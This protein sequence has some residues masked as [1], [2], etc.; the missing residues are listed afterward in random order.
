[1]VYR[2]SSKKVLSA[3]PGLVWLDTDDVAAYAEGRRVFGLPN[4][5]A[6][7]SRVE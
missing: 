6:A 7:K 3:L 2:A 4:T 5:Q 1:M